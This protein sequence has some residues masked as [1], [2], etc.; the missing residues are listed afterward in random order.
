MHVKLLPLVVSV[1]LSSLALTQS[2]SA[3]TSEPTPERRWHALSLIGEP[4]YQPGFQHFDYVNPDA[5]KG[6]SVRIGAAGSY[7][8]LNTLTSKGDPA[9]GLGLIYESLMDKSL[10]QPSTAY[11]LLCEWVSYP[12]DLSSVTFKLRDGAKWHDGQPITVDDVI[13]SFETLTKNVPGWKFYYK[14]VVK[15]ERSGEREVTF[16]FDVKSNRELPH[17]MG[18]LT[19]F[20]KHFWTGKNAAGQLRDPAKSTLEVPLGSGPYRIKELKRGAS[21]TY[22]RVPD[23]WGKDLPINRGRNNLGEISYEYYQDDTVALEAFKSGRLDF[24]LETSA[25]N[26]ATAYQFP[27]FNDGRVVR[28]EMTLQVAEPMQAFV[29]NTR[30]S[31]FADA[32]VRKAF[33]LAFDF[34]EA[35][36]KLFYGA[37]KRVSSYFENTEL[38]A[39]GLPT[40]QEL[41][42]LNE[43]KDEV[44]PQ[45]FT[46]AYKLPVNNDRLDLRKNLLEAGRLLDAAGWPIQGGKRVSSKSGE[47]LK[48][49]FL[50]VQENFER[51][52]N[53]YVQQL[54]KLGI[55]A[56]L[57]IAD[58]AQYVRR[59]R[60]F[61]FDIVVGS[62]A[63]SQSPGNEQR[64]YWSSAAAD[65]ESSR[66]IIGIKS[67]AVDKLIDRVIFA[68][69]RAGLVAACRALDRVLL[70]SNYVV[71]QWYAPYER[72]A[73]WNKF[74]F[75]ATQPTQGIG[76]PDTW[77]QEPALADKL[78]SSGG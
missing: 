28:R 68:K 38:A 48:V 58:S 57:R 18:D 7:D 25:K 75:P 78:K 32:A 49:E 46:E 52:V 51:I 20:P 22:E 6:G 45:V 33:I 50:L 63:Q 11:C 37:Y 34:E 14:N 59:I 65:Q 30:R 10:D 47:P 67:K 21:I 70:W 5:P 17:I 19:V 4:K 35:N 62:F 41:D 72:L 74:G 61:D 36:K 3:Q 40:G 54:Q 12:E 1:L 39:Q 24:R 29:M 73:F 71:P 16:R 27:A 60:S 76:F 26:W 23:Y 15:A 2:A 9:E 8:T 55:D 44:P 56:S 66:N 43:L 31:K 77:W 53:P 64:D 13:F 69:D 42:I